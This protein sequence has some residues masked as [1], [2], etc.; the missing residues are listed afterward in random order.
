[1]PEGDPIVTDDPDDDVFLHCAVLARAAYLLSGDHH[2]PD[3]GEYAN[4]SILTV[5]EFFAQV[6]PDREY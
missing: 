5:R 4:I 1:V 6:F 2:L 3:L